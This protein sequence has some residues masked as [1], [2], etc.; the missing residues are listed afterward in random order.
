V[1]VAFDAPADRVPDVR[2]ILVVEASTKAGVARVD[3]LTDPAKPVAVWRGRLSASD[4]WDAERILRIDLA[5]PRRIGAL[6]VFLDIGRF[7]ANPIDAVGLLVSEPA[8]AR[9][10]A[11]GRASEWEPPAG[12]VAPAGVAWAAS[13]L[14]RSMEQR[15]WGHEQILGAP[16]VYP[17]H[18][19]YAKRAWAPHYAPY[20]LRWIAVSFG[21]RHPASA[22]LIYESSHPGSVVRVEDLTGREDRSA[23]LQ[24][25]EV[26][27]E[28]HLPVL[29]K[30]AKPLPFPCWAD[31]S[32]V[33]RVDLAPPR[34]ISALRL[35]VDT[36][37]G[38]N[39][40]IDA[41]GLV[42]ASRSRTE[43]P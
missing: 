4:A 35:V 26:L 1:T 3:D 41:V 7:D 23:E 8:P 40:Q 25:P 10:P 6:R 43:V 17:K 2:A 16:D 39:S 12:S 22:V 19:G 28:G 32:R 37:K 14:S 24:G 9:P 38:C 15:D 42:L 33:L 18:D 21:A 5:K 30:N 29:G 36:G 20:G 27:W 11:P 13:V 34:E 31:K